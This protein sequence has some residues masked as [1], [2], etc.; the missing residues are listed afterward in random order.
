M[1]VH[2]ST[3]E[4]HSERAVKARKKPLSVTAVAIVSHLK[5]FP[6]FSLGLSNRKYNHDGHVEIPR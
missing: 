1:P 6:F 2:F 5:L 4:G 3:K